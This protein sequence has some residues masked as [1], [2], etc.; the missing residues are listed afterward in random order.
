ME[1]R[2]YKKPEE[3]SRP[4]AG[5]QIPVRSQVRVASLATSEALVLS[6][7]NAHRD[8]AMAEWLQA[9]R[10]VGRWL[11]QHHLRPVVGAAGDAFKL[12]ADHSLALTY[13][14][15]WAVAQTRPDRASTP[16]GREEW[17]S[18]TSWRPTLAALC[19]YGFEPV[20]HF[21]DRYHAQSDEVASSH[22]CGLW[23][24]GPS[25]YYRYLE[26]AK[27]ALATSLRTGTL[28]A[29]QRLS[30]RAWVKTRVVQALRLNDEA[31]VQ[32]WHAAQVPSALLL[33][34]VASALWHQRESADIEAFTALVR[35]CAVELANEAETDAL[36]D[37]A[38]VDSVRP[39]QRFDL[40]L[41][42]A[43]VWRIRGVADRE[44]GAYEQ[45]L[46][47][48][49]NAGDAL[50][51]GRIY[52]VMARFYET[53][54]ADR[55]FAF[56]QDCTDQLWRAN[57][58]ADAEVTNDPLHNMRAAHDLALIDEFVVAL[59]RLGWTYA[60]RND[61][62]S[63]TALDRAQVLRLRFEL[64]TDTAALLEQTWGEYW[65]RAGDLPRALEHK[66]RALNLYERAADR[67]SVLKTYCNL[68]LLYG[69]AKDFA[70]AIEYSQRVLGLSA[71]MHLEPE[72]VAST[73]L[74]L[75]VAHFWNGDMV[76]ATEQYELA[77]HVA[78]RAQ[79]RLTARTA[80][81]NLAE[82]AYLQF[83]QSRDK[84]DELRGDLH[85]AAALT[86]WPYPS[87][88]S[89][90]EA[91]KKLKGEILGA[92]SANAADRLAP[93][94]AVLYPSELSEVQSQRDVLALPS[95]PEPH[96]RA[97][98]RIA[99]AYLLV[100]MKEREAAL[101]LMQRH[102]M[103][104][105]FSAELAALQTTFERELTYEQQLA[106]RWTDEASDLLSNARCNAVLA[107]LIAA[108]ALNKSGYA[109]LCALSPATASKH[110]ASLAQR[111]LLTQTG[112]GPSTRYVLPEV[113]SKARTG[114]ST[115]SR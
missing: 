91:T 62:R 66:H 33:G 21:R 34:D 52:S 80:H 109:E 61:P 26:K 104:D 47:I 88:A 32:A 77:L 79:L 54:D 64:S 19:H 14:L 74:N 56:Y 108:G 1:T 3:G 30:L 13:L 72:L 50:L 90:A 93:Q 89:Y 37:T 6:A 40:L 115:I 63:K 4:G 65:R 92:S 25:T 7:L 16:I 43:A 101:A 41:A 31:E 113:T 70:R 100:A 76:L 106:R 69:E 105:Q 78:M 29:A 81:Y 83:K 94:E 22:L 8:G 42:H 12:H 15:Q 68:S 55:A 17:L 36:I 97:H 67:A 85:A 86:V 95:S 102:G 75:G 45:A 53:R 73:H 111:G 35:R 84:A 24:V 38:A 107:R 59:V 51:L 10:R 99:A 71:T 2:S 11:A 60:V 5:S 9:H 110:L 44:H 39:Q 28:D 114:I 48:A 46:Q 87:D 112:K 27:R 98:L 49:V 23:S 82:V 57:V 103:A 96:V 18:R 20:Q 58:G